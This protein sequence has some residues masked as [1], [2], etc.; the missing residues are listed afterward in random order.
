MAEVKVTDLPAITLDSFTNNDS[1]LIID[2]GAVR[3]LTRAVFYEWLAGNVQGQRGE[4]GVAGRDGV[5]GTNGL[6]GTNGTNGIS[7][8]Q[9]AV[10]NG[11]VGSA[12]AWLASMKGDAGAKGLDGGDGWSP[13]FKTED[14]QGGSYLKIVDWVG[15]TGEKPVTLGY[16]SNEGIVSTVA[17][18]TNLKGD[19]GITGAKGETGEKGEKGDKGDRGFDGATGTNA[20]YLAVESGFVGT[21]EQWLISLNPSEVSKAP[22]NIISKKI[23]GMFAPATDPLEM[24]NSIDALPDKNIMT[25]AQKDKLEA[26]KTSKYLGTFLTSEEIPLEGAEAGNY[27]DV[28]SG[29]SDV[30]TERWIYDVDSLKFVKSVSI[31]ASETS[32]S[33]KEKY[34]SNPD[35]NAYTDLEKVK[36]EG[37]EEETSETVKTKY[38]SNPDTNAFTDDEKAKLAGLPS[39]VIPETEESIKEKYESNL[40][41]NVFTDA[42]KS[43]LSELTVGSINENGLTPLKF[44][45]GTQEEY[46]LIIDKDSTTLY[47]VK[48]SSE[49]P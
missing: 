40:D 10:Q 45:V 35:T 43:K 18:A 4:Q 48:E 30:D 21:Q 28:D 49:A 5:R 26:L 47:V 24:A 2:D 37:L 19:I 15:G 31:P 33:V 3:R 17:V 38:E 29:E 44:W 8:Y 32:E 9:V 1:F 34:E 14:Y 16:V 20:Y 11:F 7:A 39:E 13:V 25:D 36:L 41:T 22:N 27:A 46:D 12:E 6:N 42:E 23:D